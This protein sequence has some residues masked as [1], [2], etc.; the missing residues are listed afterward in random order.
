MK[1]LILITILPILLMT[2]CAQTLTQVGKS[3]QSEFH[4]GL[5][6]KVTL[7]SYSG[8]PIRVWEG[9]NIIIN[10][11][12]GGETE[13]IVDGKKVSVSGVFVIEEK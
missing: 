3:V 6:R 12:E 7:Y 13:M 2:G 1:K 5:D 10:G 9:P 8:Q 4:G 11:T